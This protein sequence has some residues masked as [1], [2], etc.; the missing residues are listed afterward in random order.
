[1]NRKGWMVFPLVSAVMLL[2]AGSCGEPEVE[3]AERDSYIATTDGVSKIY[4][5]DDRGAAIADLSPLRDSMTGIKSPVLVGKSQEIAFLSA[6]KP[7]FPDYLCVV[8][9]RGENLRVYE[10]T[11]VQQLGGSPMRSELVFTISATERRIRIVKT[12]EGR[13]DIRL[14]FTDALIPSEA[15][16]TIYFEQAIEPVFSP[17][18]S[19]VAFVNVGYYWGMGPLGPEKE[20]RTD[21]GIVQSDGTGYRLLTGDESEALSMATWLQVLWSYDSKWI[22]AVQGSETIDCIYAVRVSDG[23]VFYLTRDF[24]SSYNYI[25]ASPIGDSLILG[26]VVPHADLY[27]LEYSDETGEFKLGAKIAGRLTDAGIYAQPDW[28]PGK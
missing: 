23:R 27:V 15:V 16:D 1:M 12:S 8:D 18:G 4:V 3:W 28:G 22:F 2:A 24:F 25:T 19:Q 10:V 7:G 21:I 20:S 14:L 17:D 26:T 5:L 13:D 9:R 11:Q 6:L